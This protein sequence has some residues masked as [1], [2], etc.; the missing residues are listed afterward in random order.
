MYAVNIT[1]SQESKSVS[2]SYC[3]PFLLNIFWKCC[4]PVY[5]GLLC[6][7]CHQNLLFFLLFKVDLY[8]AFFCLSGRNSSM[9]SRSATAPAAGNQSLIS[10]WLNGDSS[11]GRLETTHML[12]SHTLSVNSLDVLGQ[13][14]VCGTDGEAVYVHKRVRV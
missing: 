10:A 9:M 6:S 14:L 1:H 11:K 13:C 8:C 12:P 3:F 7:H 2:S 5:C 4:Q